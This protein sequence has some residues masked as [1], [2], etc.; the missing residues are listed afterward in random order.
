LESG[1]SAKFESGGLSKEGEDLGR[2]E[3]KKELIGGEIE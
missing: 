2:K 1:V 3:R